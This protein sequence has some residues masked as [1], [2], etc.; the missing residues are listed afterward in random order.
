MENE[1]EY[2]GEVSD[3]AEMVPEVPPVAVPVAVVSPLNV[4]VPEIPDNLESPSPGPFS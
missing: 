4:E 3:Q 2:Y 1:D